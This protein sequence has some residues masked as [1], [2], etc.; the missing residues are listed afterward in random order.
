MN[1]EGHQPP[2]P[3]STYFD[4]PELEFVGSNQRCRPFAVFGTMLLNR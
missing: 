4:H 2:L 1:L 3:F